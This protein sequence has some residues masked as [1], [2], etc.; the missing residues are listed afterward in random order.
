MQFQTP[1]TYT[2]TVTYTSSDANYA[3]VRNVDSETFWVH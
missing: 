3:S 2:V 1:G